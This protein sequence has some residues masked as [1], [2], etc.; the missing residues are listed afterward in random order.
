MNRKIFKKIYEV[1]E[2]IPKG[3]VTTYGAI[4]KKVGTSPRVVGFALHKNPDLKN[5]PCH[6]VVG[7]SGHLA[8]YVNGIEKKRELL[9]RE[10]VKFIS[11]WRV[12]L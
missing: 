12:N 2:K 8:G 10:G 4:A 7:K 5:I 3:K 11:K 9:K 6:R 1:V